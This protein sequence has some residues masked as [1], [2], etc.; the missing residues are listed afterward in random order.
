MRLHTYLIMFV[1]MLM[2][3]ATLQFTN[4]AECVKMHTD[5][6]CVSHLLL[7]E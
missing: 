7:K 3:L 1:L 6:H 5:N 2:V 4:Y